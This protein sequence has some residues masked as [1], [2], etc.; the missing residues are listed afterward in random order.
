MNCD[1]S[2]SADRTA[3]CD[4]FEFDLQFELDGSC[5]A[6]CSLE[7]RKSKRERGIGREEKFGR[8]EQIQ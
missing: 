5:F 4:D 1:E 6:G 7:L 8:K 2:I 3:G